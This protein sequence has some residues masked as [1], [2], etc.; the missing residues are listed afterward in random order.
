[1]WKGL[2]SS[3]N[4]YYPHSGTLGTGAIRECKHTVSYECPRMAGIGCHVGTLLY[5]S[6]KVAPNP[7]LRQY[8]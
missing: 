6:K 5:Y 7:I 3:T 8:P 1:M 2:L 4:G